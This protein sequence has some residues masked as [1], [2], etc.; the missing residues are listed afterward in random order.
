M[1]K[2]AAVE[3]IAPGANPAFNAT[4]HGV[5]SRRAVLPWEATDEYEDLRRAL[6]DEHRPAG[7]TEEHL[8][9][10]LAD[11][12]WRMRRLR[13]A[14]NATHEE[15]L[16]ER[17]SDHREARR[18]IGGAL[19]S[20]T[21]TRPDVEDADLRE[22]VAGE[23][24]AEA[25]LALFEGLMDAADKAREILEQSP[26]ERGLKEAV[27]ALAP[28]TRGWFLDQVKERDREATPEGLKAF[29]EHE[30]CPWMEK[31]A[32]ALRHRDRLRAHVQATSFDAERLETLAR[33]ETHL[34]RKLQ[35]TLSTLFR[36]KEL[37]SGTGTAA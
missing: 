16:Y 11:V 2:T 31:R 35:R 3:V 37:R 8:V 14:E 21:T 28:E 7:P 12:L 24:D 15:A 1:T 32:V 36:L 6:A 13:A 23:G 22:A 29:L 17:L 5:L 20:V 26:T 19:A 18:M 34:D 4:R 25:D 30:A 10:E 9:G 33:Y 27:A